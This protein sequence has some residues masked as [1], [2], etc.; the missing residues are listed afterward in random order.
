MTLTIPFQYADQIPLVPADEHSIAYMIDVETGEVYDE[1]GNFETAITMINSSEYIG[2]A[3]QDEVHW[4]RT[5]PLESRETCGY[6]ET[7]GPIIRTKAQLQEAFDHE[8]RLVEDC[9]NLQAVGA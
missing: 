9:F 6:C 5:W 7:Y 3:I 8:R 1:A 4:C 2:V